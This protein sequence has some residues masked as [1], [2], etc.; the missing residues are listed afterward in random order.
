MK[1]CNHCGEAV[2]VDEKYCSKCDFT[3]NNI[4]I[5]ISFNT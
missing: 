3:I 2:N 4:I 1:F 5:K